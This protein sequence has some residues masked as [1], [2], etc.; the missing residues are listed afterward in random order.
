MGWN[1]RMKSFNCSSFTENQ[2]ILHEAHQLEELYQTILKEE[3]F[4]LVLPTQSLVVV[5][6]PLVARVRNGDVKL[7]ADNKGE[8]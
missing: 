8:N 4:I 5:A 3:D 6:T 7:S 1:L 2:I